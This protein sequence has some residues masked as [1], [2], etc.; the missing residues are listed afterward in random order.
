MRRIYPG[1]F[2]VSGIPER[3]KQCLVIFAL[4]AMTGGPL[5]PLGKVSKKALTEKIALK[6][7]EEGKI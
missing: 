7:K 6:L 1:H 4:A 2:D 5:S 3:W